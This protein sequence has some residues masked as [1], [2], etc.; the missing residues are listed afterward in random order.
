MATRILKAVK[1]R[2][3]KHSAGL[4]CN[5]YDSIY[6]KSFRAK[7]RL[8]FLRGILLQRSQLIQFKRTLRNAR[9]HLKVSRKLHIASSHSQEE[10]TNTFQHFSDVLVTLPRAIKCIRM[11]REAVA[12]SSLE[13]AKMVQGHQTGWGLEQPG[14]MG[15]IPVHGW[16]I[17]TR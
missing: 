13:M 2:I 8:G 1:S 6:R 11:P 14:L 16:G 5:I 17:R 7:Q 9:E 3:I 15:G 12:A 4:K 10:E